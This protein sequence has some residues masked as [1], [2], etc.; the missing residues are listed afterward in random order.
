MRDGHAYLNKSAEDLARAMIRDADR[1]G[2]SHSRGELGEHLIDAGAKAPGGIEA[3]L[4]LIEICMGGLGTATTTLGSGKWPYGVTICSSQPVLACLASQYAGWNLS[5]EKYFA[6]GSG[7]VRALAR[8]EPLFDEIAYREPDATSSVVV[9]ET[10]SPPPR[11]VVEKVAKATDLAPD[12]LT[13]IYAPTQSLTGAVQIIGRVLEVALHKAHDLKFPLENIVDGVGRAPIPAPHPDFLRAMGRTN[14]AII[15]G[16]SVQ[17]FVRGSSDDARA[18]A[19]NL[20]S[21]TS[22]DYGQPF[23]KIFEEFKGDFYA[24]DPHLFS[25]AEVIVTA[26]ETGDTFRNGEI[27]E[28]MLEQSLG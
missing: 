25:P 4:R 16:G 14:D 5:H 26:I 21:R 3:G 18:L 13:F 11:A 6:M 7:P 2:I 17:L 12:A 9:L 10:S 27:N 19:E 15:Y 24:I 23:A 20:P 8:V 28:A 1:L 22:R